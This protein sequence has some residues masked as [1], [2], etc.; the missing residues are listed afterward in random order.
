MYRPPTY[1]YVPPYV[2]KPVCNLLRHCFVSLYIFKQQTKKGYFKVKFKHLPI[3]LKIKFMKIN[4]FM[5]KYK[6]FLTP[7]QLST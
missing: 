3:T 7:H 4:M 2:S 5:K 1:P 6:H